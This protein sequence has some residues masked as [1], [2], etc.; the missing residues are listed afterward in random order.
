MNTVTEGQREELRGLLEAERDSLEEELIGHGRV[1]G[2]NGDWQGN[3]SGLSGT[4]ADPTDA[5]DQIEELITNVPLVE[6]LET[7]HRDIVSALERMEAGT[8]GICEVAKEPIPFAR[9]EANPAARTC[10]K[11]AR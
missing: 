6:E 11:H 8:Y 7:R 3:S 10:I 2:E 1:Q 5:A 9:L 4:E